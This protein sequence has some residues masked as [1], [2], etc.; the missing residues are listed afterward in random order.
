M[1]A[2]DAAAAA[3]AAAEEAE[4]AAEAAAMADNLVD[5]EMYRDTAQTKEGEA[6]G[7]QATAQ[8]AS[9]NAIADARF[10]ENT[11]ADALAGPISSAETAASS[12]QTA[13]DNAKRDADAEY[14][15]AKAART[16]AD[17]TDED[18]EGSVADAVAAAQAAVTAANNAANR[19]AVA[20]STIMNADSTQTIAAEVEKARAA[21]RDAATAMTDAA[22]ALEAAM[23]AAGE[24]VL[25]LFR[26]ANALDVPDANMMT[27]ENEAAEI[28]LDAIVMQVNTAAEVEATTSDT[29]INSG[30]TDPSDVTV[31]YPL[32]TKDDPDTE[33][34]DESAAAKRA[35][36][37][38]G[39]GETIAAIDFTVA[40][41]AAEG[42]MPE[43]TKTYLRS[44]GSMGDFAGVEL[45]KGDGIAH[46]YTNIM[47]T[48]EGATT[49][50]EVT[51]TDSTR[52]DVNIVSDSTATGFN[53]DDIMGLAPV[54]DKSET[55]DMDE[56]MVNGAQAFMGTLT[57]DH[58]NDAAN[59]DVTY[60]GQ[61]TCKDTG[62]CVVERGA[63]SAVISLTNYE[64]VPNDTQTETQEV[65]ADDTVD[66]D[67]LTFGVWLD[68]DATSSEIGV[69]ARGN[70]DNSNLFTV[71][72]IQALGGTAS[73]SGPAVGVYTDGS[74]VEHFDGTANL[75]A[76]FGLAGGADADDP[77]TTGDDT[78]GEF[79][80]IEGIVTINGG[81]NT[82]AGT[83][84]LGRTDMDDG[85]F[86]GSAWKGA[87]NPVDPE[88][89][90]S[91]GY[92]YQG[93]WGGQFFGN[94]AADAEGD[95][96]QPG[97]VAGT[98]GVTGMDDDVTRSWIGAFGAEKQ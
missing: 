83:V 10:L 63:G 35:F 80:Y 14:D 48:D 19:V 46:V 3:E 2:N 44:L 78:T 33:D 7:H 5:A 81:G 54:A 31:M 90:V 37:F 70:N 84:N 34:M 36:T 87:A 61:F 18:D 91:T 30:G 62:V 16:H 82:P 75:M 71:D 8:T 51:T 28:R 27:E 26:A 59:D 97:S 13:A 94:P 93:T 47:Q 40:D 42:T 15:K 12:A 43:A 74:S 76:N 52:I 72:N 92:A 50:K 95:A 65:K 79:G 89:G 21:M 29:N 25:A 55:T 39:A 56:S 67:F 60:E 22:S 57:Y 77:D 41:D 85:P 20:K 68:N 11:R 88:T 66:T 17:D 69:F 45:T 24:H 98:F 64:F 1:V 96:M 86:A 49:E 32:D 73:Y 4:A 23:A 58:D 38:T 9:T 53:F 6:Q